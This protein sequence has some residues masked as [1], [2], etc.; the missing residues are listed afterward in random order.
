MPDWSCDLSACTFSVRTSGEFNAAVSSLPTL[1]S[2]S[3]NRDGATGPAL[4]GAACEELV[5]SVCDPEAAAPPFK[6]IL[7][8]AVSPFFSCNQAIGRKLENFKCDR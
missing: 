5:F 4:A 6:S 1:L 8:P 7:M 2:L 3:D